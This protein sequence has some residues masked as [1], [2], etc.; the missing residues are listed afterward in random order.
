ME[1]GTI[2]AK[3]GRISSSSWNNFWRK[4][5]DYREEVKRFLGGSWKNS[6]QKLENKV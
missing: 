4:L 5:E 2:L 6:I 1:A 3:I